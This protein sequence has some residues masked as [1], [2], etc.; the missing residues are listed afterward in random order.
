MANGR[1]VGEW[2]FCCRMS[3]MKNTGSTMNWGSTMNSPLTKNTVLTM[4]SP[5]TM[6]LLS[7]MNSPSMK[8][9]GLTMNRGTIVAAT[10]IVGVRAFGQ[11]ACGSNWRA[12]AIGARKQLA[13]GSNWRAEAIDGVEAIDGGWSRANYCNWNNNC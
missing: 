2:R 7:T 9:M 11:L 8:N 4:N 13:R 6:N 12:E 10:S 1:I 5:L 3:T